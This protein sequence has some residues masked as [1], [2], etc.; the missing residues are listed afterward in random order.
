MA[1]GV[2]PLQTAPHRHDST[3]PTARTTT[4]APHHHN[5]AYTNHPLWEGLRGSTHSWSPRDS[6]QFV[7]NTRPMHA[8]EVLGGS[9]L[10]Q[11]GDSP[12]RPSQ[13]N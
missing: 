8:R 10:C 3:T 1:T 12:Q 6:L 7:S 9:A 4:T 13:Y 2:S 11:T 5:N